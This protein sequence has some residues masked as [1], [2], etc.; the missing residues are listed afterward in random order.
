MRYEGEMLHRVDA[1]NPLLTHSRRKARRTSAVFVFAILA[2]LGIAQPGYCVSASVSA[3]MSADGLSVAVTV[4]GGGSCGI[5]NFYIGIDAPAGSGGLFGSCEGTCTRPFGHGMVCFS[6]GAHTINAMVTGGDSGPNN[7]CVSSSAS[8]TTAVNVTRYGSVSAIP[9]RPWRAVDGSW[10]SSCDVIGTLFACPGVSPAPPN[11][12]DFSYMATDKSA[13]RSAGSAQTSADNPRWCCLPIGD[14]GVADV[15]EVRLLGCNEV[16]DEQGVVV[17]RKDNECDSCPDPSAHGNPIKITNGDMRYVDADALPAGPFPFHRTYDSTRSPES[18]LFGNGWSSPLDAYL[19]TETAPNG[20]RWVS[21][22]TPDENRRVFASSGAGYIQKFPQ[23]QNPASFSYDTLTG[24]Y[25]LREYGADVAT[26]YRGSDGRIA[27]MR[28]LSTGR[29]MTVTYTAGLP[30]HVDDSW[31]N[32]GWTITAPNALITSIAVDGQANVWNYTYDGNANLTTVDLNGTTWRTYAYVSGGLSA[33]HD[34]AG[35]LIESHTYDSDGYAISSVG[36]SGDISGVSYGFGNGGTYASDGGYPENEDTVQTTWTSGTVTTST[37]RFIAGRF[38]VVQTS[39][40]CVSCGIQDVTYSYNG[41]GQRERVQDARGYITLQTFD[42][43]G[44]LLST[45]G[46]YRPSGCDPET[47]SI[48]CRLT[49]D[50]LHDNAPVATAATG[51]I[52]YLYGDATWTDRPTFI[53]TQSVC[54][55][56]QLRTETLVYDPVRGT[57]LSDVTAGFTGSPA[58]GE[59]HATVTALYNGTEGAAFDPGSVFS[60]GWTA[61]PQPVGLRKSVDGPRTDVSDVTTWVYYPMDASVPG[62]L[63]GH[64]AAI[65]DAAGHVTQFSSYDVFGNA[66]RGVDPN[67]VATESTYDPLGRALTSTLKG[68]AGCNTAADPLCAT[69]LTT[70]QTYAPATGP[71]ALAQRAGGGVTTWTYD[72]RGRVATQSR[73]AS[74]SALTERLTYAYDPLSGK[75]SSDQSSAFESGAWVVKRSETYTYNVTGLLATVVHPGGSSA[76]YTYGPDG[77]IATV[78]DENHA[79]PNT[80][81]AYDPAGRLATVRQTLAGA[82]GGQIA[83][84]YGYDIQGNLISVT[85]PNGNVTTYVYDDFGRMLSQASPVTGTTTYGYDRAGNLLSTTDANGATTVRTYDPLNRVLTATSSRTDLDTEA[86]VYTYDTAAEGGFGVGRLSQLGAPAISTIYTY[87]RRGLLTATDDGDFVVTYGYDADGNRTSLGYPSGQVVSYSY[88]FA[89]RPVAASSASKL[90]VTSASYLPFGPLASMTYGNGTNRTVQ[91]DS[92]YRPTE[93]KLATASTVIA[94]YLYQNDAIGNITQ[95]RDAVTPTYNRDFGYDDLNRLTTAN[96][97]AAL[98]G[99]G[100]YAYDAMGNMTSLHLGSRTLTF[101]YAGTTPR[102][103]S[104]SGTY[105]AT[106]SYDAAGNETLGDYSARNLLQRV[107]QINTIDSR[108]EYDYDGRGVRAHAY[109]ISPGP[110]PWGGTKTRRSFY[111]PELHLLAQSDWEQF[112]EDGWFNGTEYIWFGDQPVAQTFTD[113]TLPSRYTFTDH[114]GTPLL[115]TASGT[116]VVWRAEYEPYGRIYSY[117][118]GDS[119]D[120]QTL[121]LP[122]QDAAEFS[123]LTGTESSYNIFRWYSS[124][125]GRY[126][127]NDPIRTGAAV[128]PYGYVRQRPTVLIDPLGLKETA[129]TN[130]QAFQ[131]CCEKAL[132]QALFDMH[133]APGGGMV[134]CCNGHKVA[135]ARQRDVMSQMN[136]SGQRAYT[137]ALQCVLAHE[138]SHVIDLPLCKCGSDYPAHFEGKWWKGQR[139]SSEC[140]ATGVEIDCLENAKQQ[141][142][143]DP[144]CINAMELLKTSPYGPQGLR[145]RFGC[146]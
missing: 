92:R 47:S 113:P 116:S 29:E 10:R 130:D 103:T 96:S 38:R 54:S 58:A 69:D 32:W 128:D 20:V 11:A 123:D 13:A 26:Y 95:I 102:L 6:R 77:S 144:L 126:T 62:L 101:A 94:D 28:S 19:V 65:R 146:Q 106:V 52:T 138:E 63:R 24:L 105:P 55:P 90:F 122:G 23:G 18:R 67:G 93:N 119:S 118:V 50:A 17:P 82:S 60:P 53:S 33:A 120:P 99:S 56:G 87:E 83:T 15:V 22:A 139:A 46:P 5:S 51:T 81:Y 111:S 4:T 125:W 74:G 48:H 127:Q 72:G 64:L 132:G 129:I 16:Q 112:M 42:L 85:D 137:L 115:Q 91:Y 75:K 1:G 110:P 108:L 71:L 88:D 89:G 104:V 31:G 7:T 45:A 14:P 135:C 78:R 25:A 84:S 121:R 73:G 79:S 34:A 37:I 57:T 134:M 117:R 145:R 142:N 27:K 114:L 61:L 12:V 9:G 107:G 97:G 41:S 36:P 44:R 30:S 124:S 76:A 59:Q 35:N 98:W 66:T 109:S 80:T 40:G 143:G 86:V 8:A 39:G 2:L 133:N 141:C 49:T 68:V 3:A 140:V 131:P 21:I 43:A 70:S 100:S 136:A